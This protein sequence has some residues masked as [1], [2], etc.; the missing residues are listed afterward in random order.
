MCSS[1]RYL[2]GPFLVQMTLKEQADLGFALLFRKKKR[3]HQKQTDQSGAVQFFDQ[4]PEQQTSV[5]AVDWRLA[6]ERSGS[7]SPE[8]PEFTT[9]IHMKGK[10]SLNGLFLLTF[11]TLGRAP[12][13]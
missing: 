1:I 13:S 10:M 11:S 3:V 5:G 2:I 9:G 7:G 4:V 12:H 8:V 6:S